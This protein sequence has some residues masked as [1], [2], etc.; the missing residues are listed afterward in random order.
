VTR[1]LRP[2]LVLL[3][4]ALAAASP[5]TSR[6]Q[7]RD[8][9]VVA[10]PTPAP[11]AQPEAPSSG[12]VRL[13]T[14]PRGWVGDVLKDAFVAVLRWVADAL[15]EVLAATLASST[16]VLT[17]TPPDV[18]YANGTVRGLW[19]TTRWI[20]NL[21]L[22]LVALW[23]GFGLMARG[24]L[25][26]P[27]QAAMELLP[28]L[29]VGA[30][31]VNTSLWWAAL[32]VDAN[33]ALCQALGGGG[34]PAWDRASP[35]T[36]ALVDLIAVL[37]YLVTGLLLL[38]QMLIRLALV[39]VL[40]AVAPLGLLCWVLP[41]TGGWA[42]LWCRTFVA[43]IFTQFVQVLALRLGGALLVE[44]APGG[45]EAR[46]LRLF[47]GVA[48]MVLTLKVPELMRAGLGDGLGFYR[49]YVYRQAG[50]ALES[51]GAGVP[52]RGGR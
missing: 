45:D 36:P 29:V 5:L 44:T 1:A 16:N 14:D 12:L 31:L 48:V 30:L 21:G 8:D 19:D 25:G 6:A 11:A 24:Q 20:A 40:I 27:Y 9:G 47:L 43:T 42:N 10:T 17:Q 7:T 35:E 4:L 51:A 41:Q 28:R 34:L 38:L 18:S 50:R 3:L 13:L 2:L 22:G 37:A 52:P 49:S 46:A 33:N 26:A 32:A 39:D 15:R 23:G